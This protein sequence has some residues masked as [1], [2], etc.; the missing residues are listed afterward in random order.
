[1]EKEAK[2]AAKTSKVTAVTPAGGKK[3]KAEKEKK[4]TE[5]E[6]VNTT[7]PGQKKGMLHVVQLRQGV[8]I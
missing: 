6:F 2:L 8:N 3:A 1:L 4:E 7:I 5:P